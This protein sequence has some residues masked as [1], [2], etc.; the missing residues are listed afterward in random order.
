MRLNFRS[1]L[2]SAALAAFLGTVHAGGLWSISADPLIH[3]TE[4]SRWTSKSSVTE[5]SPG[6]WQVVSTGTNISGGTNYNS[7]VNLTANGTVSPTST[8]NLGDVAT[9]AVITQ[10]WGVTMPKGQDFSGTVTWHG[11]ATAFPC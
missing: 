7:T 3:E 8:Y 6:V 9:G 11:C 2:C 10:T 4:N 1:A 5:T